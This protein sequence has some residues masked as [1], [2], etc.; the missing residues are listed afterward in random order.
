M[1]N[2]IQ[3]YALLTAPGQPLSPLQQPS[4]P[5]SHYERICRAPPRP[6]ARGSAAVPIR[7]R[8][9]PLAVSVHYVSPTLH[10]LKGLL[11]RQLDSVHSQICLDLALVNAKRPD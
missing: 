10:P 5:T 3:Q 8:S 2:R 7:R 6:S 1:M 4:P 11:R 9:L